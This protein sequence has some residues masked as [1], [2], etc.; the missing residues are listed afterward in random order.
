MVDTFTVQ[1]RLDQLRQLL[2]NLKQ[3][4]GHQLNNNCTSTE[5]TVVHT[6][7][8]HVHFALNCPIFKTTYYLL[9]QMLTELCNMPKDLFTFNYHQKEQTTYEIEV[10]SQ[11]FEKILD[12]HTLA[13]TAFWPINENSGRNF[14]ERNVTKQNA[15]A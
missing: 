7:Q 1:T 13:I 11:I 3:D 4:G 9:L 15:M 14:F 8:R 2:F 6:V 12:C 10:K 5:M